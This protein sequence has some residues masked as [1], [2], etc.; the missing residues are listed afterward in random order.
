M[1]H[2]TGSLK[3]IDKRSGAATCWTDHQPLFLQEYQQ[4]CVEW[5]QQRIQLQKQVAAL[6]DQNK[7][8]NDELTL[9]SVRSAEFLHPAMTATHTPTTGL[10]RAL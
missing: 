10:K 8:L 5:E 1:S 4:L 9:S 2:I 7:R 6:E 3:I